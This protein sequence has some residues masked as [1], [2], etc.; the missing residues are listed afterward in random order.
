[1]KDL[2]IYKI[3]VKGYLSSQ[4]ANWFLGMEMS[5]TNLGETCLCGLIPD[6]AALHGILARIRD[7]GLELIS[8]QRIDV[9][10]YPGGADQFYKYINKGSNVDSYV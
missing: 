1:V 6:Q 7:L 9:D 5:Q 8:L 3:C 2:A 10:Q 4:W